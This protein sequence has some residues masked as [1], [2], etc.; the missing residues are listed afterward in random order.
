[1]GPF[2]RLVEYATGRESPQIE[3]LSCL[4]RRILSALPGFPSC[5][6]AYA[7]SMRVTKFEHSAL[8]IDESGQTLVIDPGAFTR[9]LG[10]LTSVAAIVITH[11]HPDHWTAAQLE[12]LLDSNPEA[13]ILGPLGVAT[14]AG[15]AGFTVETVADGDTVEVGPFTLRFA[16]TTHAVIHSSLP[17]I[18]NTGVLVNGTLF[19]PGDS[20]TVPEFPVAVLATPVGAPWLKIGEAIDYVTAVAPGSILPIHEAT[21]SD[22]GFAMHADRLKAAVEGVGGTSTVVAAGES[23]EL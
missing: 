4:W 19:H 16:G 7:E 21:L 10:S 14:A 2:L 13:R 3:A 17:T 5:L 9:P 22:V 23:I 6:R 1:M 15:K 8:A 12:S 18:D 11:E 20:F